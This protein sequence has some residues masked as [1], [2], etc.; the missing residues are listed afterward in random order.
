MASIDRFTGWFCLVYEFLA[1]NTM[2]L[3]CVQEACMYVTKT[4]TSDGSAV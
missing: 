2:Q 3:Y 1:A 4:E